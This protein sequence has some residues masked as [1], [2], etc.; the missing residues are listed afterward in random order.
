LPEI[1][2]EVL[3]AAPNAAGKILVTARNWLQH[4]AIR[5][6][7]AS[8]NHPVRRLRGIIVPSI[9]RERLGIRR[10]MG[11]PE[12]AERGCQHD[13]AVHDGAGVMVGRR[14]MGQQGVSCPDDSET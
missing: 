4:V 8:E 2:D 14:D 3:Q 13:S 9:F 12:K 11:A 1:A 7:I 5:K 10:N 6:L